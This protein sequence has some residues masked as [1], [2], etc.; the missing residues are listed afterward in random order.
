MLSYKPTASDVQDWDKECADVYFATLNRAIIK[1]NGRDELDMADIHEIM[2]DLTEYI[3][4]IDL[5][6]H[7]DYMLKLGDICKEISLTEEVK[8]KEQAFAIAGDV[9]LEYVMIEDNTPEEAK[10]RIR[11]LITELC[12]V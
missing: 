1:L 12:E 5:D 4:G 8:T 7:M 9:V 11:S 6:A 10:D 3:M 2:N